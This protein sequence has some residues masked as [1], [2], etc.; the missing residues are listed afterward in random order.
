MINNPI[1][2]WYK[3][4]GAEG[5]YLYV[6]GPSGYVFAQWY[7]ATNLCGA[8]TCSVTGATTLGAGARGWISTPV[9][10]PA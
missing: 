10:N 4:T 7:S 9:T 3:V 2:T 1:Y 6:S 5:Y 8:S